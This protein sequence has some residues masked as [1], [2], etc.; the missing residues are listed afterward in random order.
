[1]KEKREKERLIKWTERRTGGDNSDDSSKSHHDKH[2]DKHDISDNY[3]ISDATHLT[4]GDV[5]MRTACASRDTTR[6][7]QEINL[8][9]TQTHQATSNSTKRTTAITSAKAR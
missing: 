7:D 5:T 6:E 9:Q 3:D 1:M 8:P 4:M 2:R